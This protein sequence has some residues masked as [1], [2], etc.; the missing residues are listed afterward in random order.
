MSNLFLVLGALFVLSFVPLAFLFVRGYFHFRGERLVTCPQNGQFARVRLDAAKAARS[1]LSDDADLK[2]TACERWP[3][4]QDCA[5]G[6]V[7]AGAPIPLAAP[8]PSAA[9]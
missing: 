8:Q 1:S 7:E 2:V 4:H 9:K 3:D 6:C 5:Q